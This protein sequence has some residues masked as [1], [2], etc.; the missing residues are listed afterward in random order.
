MVLTSEKESQMNQ[1][2]NTLGEIE[3]NLRIIKEKEQIIAL[4]ADQGDTKGASADEINKDIRLIYDLMVQNKERIQS[5]EQQLKKSGIETSRLNHLVSN[6]NENLR[7]KNLEVMQLSELL[8]NKD[9]EIDDLTY[10]ITGMEVTLDSIRSVNEETN[11]ALTTTKGDLYTAYYAIG[12]RSELKDKNIINREGFLFF[13]KTEVLQKNFDKTYFSPL[14]INT[15]DTIPTYQVRAKVLSTHPAGSYT[16][17]TDSNGY[18]QL[19]IKDKKQF[20]SVS[21]YLVLRVN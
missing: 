14:D 20:W 21:K 3:A 7:K 6:L 1:M 8:K 13:G 5:L 11:K 16:M 17:E 4:K 9:L 12:T 10:A 18:A 2:V 19:I 15:T